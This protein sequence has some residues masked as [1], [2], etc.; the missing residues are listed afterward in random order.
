LGKGSLFG[1]QCWIFSFHKRKEFFLTSASNNQL[2]TDDSATRLVYIVIGLF[3]FFHN[4]NNIVLCCRDSTMEFICQMYMTLVDCMM[5]LNMDYIFIQMRRC[6]T[7][8]L[9]FAALWSLVFTFVPTTAQSWNSVPF[10]WLT[11]KD[12]LIPY[13]EL[14][15]YG[16]PPT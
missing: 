8:L 14:R 12:I 9:L 16:P 10:S 2:F 7:L 4:I 6:A 1:T 5:P 11:L 13:T 15:H 3:T